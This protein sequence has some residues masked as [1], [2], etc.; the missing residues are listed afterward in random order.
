MTIAELFPEVS[1]HRPIPANSHTDQ[2]RKYRPPPIVPPYLQPFLPPLPW[3]TRR[4]IVTPHI[5]CPHC[6]DHAFMLD[7]DTGITCVTCAKAPN[8]PISKELPPL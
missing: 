1:A 4:I 2:K 6:R 5:R 3:D 8:L 7:P